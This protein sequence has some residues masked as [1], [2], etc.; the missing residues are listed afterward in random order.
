MTA[1]EASLRDASQVWD[2]FPPGLDE[3]GES[4]LNR[5][6]AKLR[7]VL[8]AFL[9]VQSQ[10]KADRDDFFDAFNN[11]IDSARQDIG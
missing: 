8:P 5:E 2:L 3:A 6:V 9:R 4:G 1:A 10:Y 7:G 11:L